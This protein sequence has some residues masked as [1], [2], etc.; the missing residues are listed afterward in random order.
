MINK[1][2]TTIICIIILLGIISTSGCTS[3]QTNPSTD[4]YLQTQ[5]PPSTYGGNET[6]ITAWISSKSKQ[7]YKNI[8][9]LVTGLDSEN[10]AVAQ[11]KV[12]VDYMDMDTYRHTGFTVRLPSPSV[13]HITVTVLN[14]TKV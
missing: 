14:A 4:I 10:G 5:N 9:L 3:S 6:E 7:S 8:E 13:D 12:Y 1:K 2:T 11:K